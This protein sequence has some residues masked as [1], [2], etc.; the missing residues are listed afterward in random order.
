MWLGL[1]LTGMTF[2]VAHTLGAG[3]HDLDR[4]ASTWVYDGLEVLAVVAVA[5]RAVLIRTERLVWGLLAVGIGFW[6]LG[7]LSWNLIYGGNPPFPSLADVF[8]LGFYPPTY[9]ALVLLVRHRV[10]RFNASVW[11]DGVTVALVT[12][13]VGAAVLLEVVIHDTHGTLPAEAANLAYPIGDIVL[14]ALV[15]AVYALSGGRPGPGWAPIGGALTLSAVADGIYLY[16]TADGSYVP[17]TWLDALWPAALILLALAAWSPPGRRSHVQLEGRPLAATPLVCGLVAVGVLVDSY[18]QGRNAVGVALAAAAIVTVA[19]RAALMFRENAEMNSHMNLLAS[20]DSLTGL[21]NRRKLMSDLDRVFVQNDGTQRLFVLFDLNGFKR[22]NDTFGHPTGDALLA[23]LATKLELAVGGAGTCY[24]LGGDEFCTLAPV[25]TSGIERFLDLTTGAL[26]ES[27]EA[28]EITTAFGCTILPEEAGTPGDALHVAD[29]RLYAQKYQFLISRGRPHAVL[30]QALQEREPALRE[31]VGGVADLSLRLGASLGLSDPAIDELGLAAQL[32]DIGK[33]AIPDVVLAKTDPLD[34]R[35]LDFIRSHTLIGQRILDASP[36]LYEVGKIV[37]ATHE[38][39]DGTGYP[40]GVAGAEIPLPA[41]IIA[42]CDSYCAMI[43]QR[44]H[45][46]VHTP[47]EA[48][49]EL[50]GLAGSQF[51]PELVEVFVALDASV[52]TS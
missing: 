38:R 14:V 46:E 44:P 42:V 47:E 24:R 4:F 36:A 11:F 28:F 8:Y 34:E 19:A 12:A 21:G 17:G 10:S 1:V 23:R 33:L 41:R 37:R 25:P 40:D 43:E 30:L 50:R 2:F 32:H 5:A 26:A 31:H 15:A 18:V 45:G 9:L 20:T 13:A 39:W 35:E 22:Y 27:G 6:T 52:S 7:D 49:A 51:D 29:K 16:Q 3:G 48:V